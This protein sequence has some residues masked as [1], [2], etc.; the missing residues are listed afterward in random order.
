MARGGEHGGEEFILLFAVYL[1]AFLV[2]IVPG[3]FMF[4]FGRHDGQMGLEICGIVFLALGGLVT[5]IMGGVML[6]IAYSPT[7]YTYTEDDKRLATSCTLGIGI[8][9]LMIGII[10]GIGCGFG[11]HGA[12]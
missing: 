4:C 3:D 6:H 1:C 11:F 2:C 10:P 5:L 8:A 7:N 9:I 12:L